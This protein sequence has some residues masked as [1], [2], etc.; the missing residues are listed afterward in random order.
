MLVVSGVVVMGL[1]PGSFVVHWKGNGGNFGVIHAR[2]VVK[3]VPD[4]TVTPAGTSGLP[5]RS[6]G[7]L[8]SP[9]C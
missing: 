9:V 3:H 5:Q 4:C 2:T 7:G 8:P 6:P 1:V